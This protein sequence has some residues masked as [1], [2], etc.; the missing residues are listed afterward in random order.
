MG[1]YS[2]VISAR[3][4]NLQIPKLCDDVVGT[5][6]GPGTAVGDR[7]SGYGIEELVNVLPGRKFE[8]A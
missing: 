6:K 8:E 2:T 5:H 4:R 1:E 3:G 7:S